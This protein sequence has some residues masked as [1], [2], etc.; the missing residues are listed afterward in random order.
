M[1]DLEKPF[2][3]F[4]NFKGTHAHEEKLRA[5]SLA[6]IEADPA[7]RMRL[8]LIEKAMSLI[9]AYTH[10]HAARSDDELTIQMLGI[11]LFNAAASAIKL[12]LSGYYQTAFSQ[13]RDIMEVGFL[14]DLF[15]TSPEHIAK[16]KSSDDATR[17]EQYS[18]VN[19]RKALDE[20]DG[21]KEKKRAKQYKI[22]SELASHATYRGF[23]LTMREGLGEIGPF[24]ERVNLKAWVEEMVLRLG[25]AAVL[26]A[27]HSP[28]ANPQFERFLREF[29]TELV[30]GTKRVSE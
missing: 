27:N 29:G 14:I 8:V 5:E 13:A 30:E 2:S 21:N 22:L 16:W 1:T 23:R 20:R 7:L 6:I 4:D 24:V 17:R 15:R 12:G 9:F 18:P 25:P 28:N 3:D 11:R 19:V 10:D 26:F